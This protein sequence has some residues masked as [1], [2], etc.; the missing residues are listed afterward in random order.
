MFWEGAELQ[1]LQM[2]GISGRV[3]QLRRSSVVV[4]GLLCLPNQR[5]LVIVGWLSLSHALPILAS[6]SPLVRFRQ[7]LAEKCLRIIRLE[8]K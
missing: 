8:L 2:H 1:E 4:L 3:S 7:V 5:A 6:E